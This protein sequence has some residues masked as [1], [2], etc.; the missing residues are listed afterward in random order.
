M[1]ALRQIFGRT[2]AA[3]WKDRSIYSG[4]PQQLFGRTAA[5]IRKDRSAVAKPHL[6]LC[7]DQQSMS[8]SSS[9]FILFSK[10]W[11]LSAFVR[12]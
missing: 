4:G 1:Y 10:L 7:V 8:A 6:V 9:V 11:A 2:A 5:A 3:V 12:P